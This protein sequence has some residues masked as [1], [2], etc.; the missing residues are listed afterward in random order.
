M[1]RVLSLVVFVLAVVG[2][3]ACEEWYM[4]GSNLINDQQFADKITQDASAFKF[5][6]YFTPHCPYCRYLKAVFDDLKGRKEWCFKV[7]DFNCQWY[8]QFCRDHVKS[9]SFPYTAIHDEKGDL[10]EEIHGFYPEPII[11]KIFDRID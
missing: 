11:L 10:I 7:Y 2:P 4:P 1:P 9:S 8:P 5:V 6:K 3:I